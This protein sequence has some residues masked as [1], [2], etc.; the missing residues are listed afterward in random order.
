M[1][2]FSAGRRPK[3]KVVKTTSEDD[4]EDVEDV[5]SATESMEIEA[6]TVP[7]IKRLNRPGLSK[8]SSGS[9]LKLSFGADEVVFF[10]TS[11]NL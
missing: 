4:G 9:K 1:H 10:I 11:A 3:P 7:A 8:T 2:G 6:P 5:T